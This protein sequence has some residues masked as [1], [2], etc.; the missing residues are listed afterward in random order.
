MRCASNSSID[1]SA[2]LAKDSKRSLFFNIII[3]GGEMD[4]LEV[5]DWNYDDFGYEPE[6]D[7]EN[8]DIDFDIPEDDE[9]LDYFDDDL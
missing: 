3:L 2:F 9:F 7:P 5:E 4:P 6:L 8:D 1:S